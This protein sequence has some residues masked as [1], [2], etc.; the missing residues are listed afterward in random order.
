MNA[1][2]KLF[3]PKW[4][5]RRMPIFWWLGKLAYTRFIAR[6]LTSLAVAYAALLLLA[7]VWAL[8]RGAET[9]ARFLDL[10][11]TVPA[12]VVHTLVLGVLVFHS[13]TWLSLA[14]RA[15]VVKLG[16]RRLPDAAVLTAHYLAWI[17]ASAA[18]VW[19]LLWGIR[20]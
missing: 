18:V 16:R 20:A 5:R 3:R 14:P 11:Q 19:L 15:L 10:L 12:L 4:H 9:Y 7:Q 6:E 13:V 1:G 2:Y 8:G 17:A